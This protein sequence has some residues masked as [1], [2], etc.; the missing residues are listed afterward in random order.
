MDFLRNH[1]EA[2]IFCAPEPAKIEDMQ[3]VLEE[4]LDAK[5]PEKD[6]TQALQLLE[7]KY[8]DDAF[9][10]EL[11]MAGGGYQFLTK[12]SY[13]GAINLLLKQ[14]S[15]KKLSN[16]AME[17]LAIIAYKQP[18][19][20]AGTEQIR[21]VGCDYAIQKLLEKELIEV[22]G[23]AETVGKPILYGT[24]QKFLDYFGINSVEEL[25]TLKDF[26]RPDNEITPEEGK[27]EPREEPE[28]PAE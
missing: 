22:K 14:K 24:S 9:S 4:M 16:S 23:K 21:G 2:L 10:F 13:Q 7:E 28:T 27:T 3:A 1:V 19:T 20:K 6:I 12:P 26:E 5:V 15:K 18:V 17:T 8:K 25:P 11:V